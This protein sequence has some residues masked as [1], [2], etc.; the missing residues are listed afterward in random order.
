MT[1]I[2]ECTNTDCKFNHNGD[3]QRYLIRISKDGVCD[4][5]IRTCDINAFAD[6]VAHKGYIGQ[7]QLERFIEELEE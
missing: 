1:T 2:S 4:G 6:E 5:Y 3:C 7:Q